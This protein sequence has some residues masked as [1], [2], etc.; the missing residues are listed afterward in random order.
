MINGMIPGLHTFFTSGVSC[1]WINDYYY[2][3]NYMGWARNGF[4]LKGH[5]W[6]GLFSS[7]SLLFSLASQKSNYTDSILVLLYKTCI[8]YVLRRRN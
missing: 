6:V 1:E 8:C 5:S 4:G 7:F 3:Y 2:Y